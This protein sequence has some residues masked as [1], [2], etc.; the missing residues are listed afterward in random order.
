VR[1]TTA[2]R[3]HQNLP[4]EHADG[5]A[6]QGEAEIRTDAEGGTEYH[7]AHHADAAG[8]D[9]GTGIRISSIR[10]WMP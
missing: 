7:Q 1:R 8:D 10:G 5:V 3:T 9:H 2:T 6:G 4:R